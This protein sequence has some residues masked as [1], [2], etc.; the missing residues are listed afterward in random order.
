M[1]TATDSDSDER[2]A[3]YAGRK[4]RDTQHQ[5]LLRSDC[6]GVDTAPKPAP[7]PFEYALNQMSVTPEQAIYV[8]NSLEYDVASAHAAGTTAV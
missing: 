3:R 7:E 2:R 6:P 8:G 5:R 1:G 4:D